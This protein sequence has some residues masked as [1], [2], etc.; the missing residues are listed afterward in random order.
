M[1]SISWRDS[2][3]AQHEHKKQSN[4]WRSRR[5]IGSAQQPLIQCGDQ[6]LTNFASNDYL[7]LAAHPKLAQAMSAASEQW[8][9]GA[10]ASHLVCGHQDMH[11]RFE[12]GLAEFV[13]A[14]RVLL[15]SNGF[16]ANL[17]LNTV[18]AQKHDLL[19]HDRLNHA[20][21]IDGAQLSG[22]QFKRYAHADLVH[23]KKIVMRTE[24]QRLALVTDSVFSMDGDVAPLSQLKQL[25]DDYSAL[26]CVDDAHGFGVLGQCGR[27][28]LSGAGLAPSGNVVMMGTL[29]KSFGS[30]GAFIAADDHIIESLIQSARSYIYTTALPAPVVAAS[31]AA[32]AIVQ[33]EHADLTAH[34]GR[35][36]TLFK[37]GCHS[38]GIELKPSNTAIQPVMVGDEGRAE[39]VSRQLE[40]FGF[41]VPSIR[42]PTVAKGQA[43]LRVT[44]TAAHTSHQVDGLVLAL[45]KAF[46]AQEFNQKSA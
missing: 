40:E 30:F 26:L 9:V 34:L 18:F 36:I 1:S 12:C 14:E 8:G 15:F 24:Y 46:K 45:A 4:V 10:G 32:L 37:E 31:S 42:V 23:A 2:L 6:W 25:A 11:H 13:G 44:L 16:M 3:L 7:G 21:L 35:L 27:G 29:S 38:E 20:S 22:A 19:L 43:R 41:L 17:A 28:S 5:H 39:R 33:S